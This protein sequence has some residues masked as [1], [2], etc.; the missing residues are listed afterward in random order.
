MCR[1]IAEIGKYAVVDDAQFALMKSVTPGSYTFIV[2]ARREVPRRLTR[3]KTIGVRIPGHAVAHAL[4]AELDEPMVSATLIPQG[5]A[6]PLSDPHDI[7]EQLE[8][9]LEL[10]IDGGRCGVE[11]ST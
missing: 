5:A 8:R 1:D 9:Q 11:P 2:R 7:R 10:I 4:L 6:M 3:R